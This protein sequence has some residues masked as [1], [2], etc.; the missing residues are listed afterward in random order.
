MITAYRKKVKVRPDGRIEILEP[1]LMPGTEAEVIVLVED[2]PE[3]AETLQAR[4]REWEALFKK[5]QAL[6]QA[7]TITEEEIA[8]EIAAYRAGKKA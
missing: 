1:F 6:P 4:V 2:K 8:A 7:Q 5:T 3:S